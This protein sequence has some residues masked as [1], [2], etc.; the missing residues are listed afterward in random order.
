MPEAP[1]TN[2]LAPKT[3][4]PKAKS[5]NA[6]AFHKA[7]TGLAFSSLD[8]DIFVMRRER[9]TSHVTN[10]TSVPTATM[11]ASRP[12]VP[13][14]PTATN[15][16]QAD[17]ITGTSTLRVKALVMHGMMSAVTP[18]INP[19]FAMLDPTTLPMQMPGLSARAA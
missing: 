19:M 10:V 1:L 3:S 14:I 18:R 7:M 15:S 16:Q 17:T 5:D 11:P 6:M 9:R 8:S 12:I 4:R 13:V 2:T